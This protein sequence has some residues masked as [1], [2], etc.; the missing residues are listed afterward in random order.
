MCVISYKSLSRIIHLHPPS[1]PPPF[2]P[3]D[4]SSWICASLVL[5]CQADFMR[6]WCWFVKLVLCVTG[7]DLS[8]W[9]CA[10]LVLICQADFMRHW[11]WYVKLVLCVTGVDLSIWFCPSLVFI[12]QSG[13]VCHRCC[14]CVFDCLL[15]VLEDNTCEW[16]DMS[17]H[18]CC[19]SELAL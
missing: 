1:P 14:L 15:F 13:F 7:V 4:L 10:S 2:P 16:I 8:I 19:F 18:D 5:I 12:C 6:H 17:N 9:F 11:C 3:P